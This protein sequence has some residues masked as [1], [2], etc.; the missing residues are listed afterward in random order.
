MKSTIILIIMYKCDLY[1]RNSIKSLNRS[2]K[3][4]DLK[5]N[6]EFSNL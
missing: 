1:N 3:K 6:Y 5:T 4:Y 2:M